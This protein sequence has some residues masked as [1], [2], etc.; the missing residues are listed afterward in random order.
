VSPSRLSCR[1]AAWHIGLLAAGLLLASG[2]FAEEEGAGNGSAVASPGPAAEEAWRR[3]VEELALANEE[4]SRQ[5]ALL[6]ERLGDLRQQLEAE[7][8][9]GGEQR[10]REQRRWFLTGAAVLL[11]GLVLGLALARLGPRRRPRWGDL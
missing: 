8:R 4:L 10:R 1:P 11:A 3:Q 7:Q 9:T 5:N 2:S 6:R